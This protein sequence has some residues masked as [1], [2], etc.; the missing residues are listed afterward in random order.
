MGRRSPR[1]RSLRPKRRHYESG[2]CRQE[3]DNTF[4]HCSARA[5]L[6]MRIREIAPAYGTG[7]LTNIVTAIGWVTSAEPG[8]GCFM[9]VRDLSFERRAFE[10]HKRRV[11]G[12]CQNSCFRPKSHTC[13]PVDFSGWGEVVRGNRKRSL[14]V[15]LVLWCASRV[16]IARLF[17]R[18]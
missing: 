4:V 6:R 17:W 5:R 9:C 7:M 14:I 10:A 1:L 3:L 2:P 11:A 12:T 13:N 8:L 16:S 15:E 18:F